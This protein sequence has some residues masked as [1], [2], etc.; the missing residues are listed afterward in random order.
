[1]LAVVTCFSNRYTFWGED[2]PINF[3][4]GFSFAFRSIR[5]RETEW[6]PCHPPFSFCIKFLLLFFVSIILVS[7]PLEIKI[8]YYEL[9][10]GSLRRLCRWWRRRRSDMATN[11]HFPISDL[12]R[13][14]ETVRS[15]VRP[16]PRHSTPFVVGGVQGCA[17]LCSSTVDYCFKLMH[18]YIEV[19]KLLKVHPSGTIWKNRSFE[20]L[21]Q[22][23]NIG[24][25]FRPETFPQN[26]EHFQ[27][28][29]GMK[30]TR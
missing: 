8:K 30:F 15:G 10:V 28:S 12:R 29:P 3:T 13:A 1:M 27:A 17:R 4:K 18:M 23:S 11:R 22:R 20:I 14:K 2:L 5:E 24:G 9:R 21:S 25:N 6:Q 26:R 19:L 16:T 7:I